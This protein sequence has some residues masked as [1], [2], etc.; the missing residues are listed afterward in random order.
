MS[1]GDLDVM[2]TSVMTTRGLPY[3]FGVRSGSMLSSCGQDHDSRN[4]EKE[5]V[6]KIVI[7]MAVG[8][9]GEV[10]WGGQNAITRIMDRSF[11]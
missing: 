7:Y 9:R 8:V 11:P 1:K 4:D 6:R 2:Y 3:G 10:L 5:R